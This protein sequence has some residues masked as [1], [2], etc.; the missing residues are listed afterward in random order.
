MRCEGRIVTWRTRCFRLL[1]R[2]FADL[3]PFS[4]AQG[5]ILVQFTKVRHG[6]LPKDALYLPKVGHDQLL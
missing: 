4:L 6:V 2:L 3:F 1:A 5:Y